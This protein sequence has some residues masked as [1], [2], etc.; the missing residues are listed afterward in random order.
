MDEHW[1]PMR[2]FKDNLDGPV[3][4]NIFS[5]SCHGKLFLGGV[6]IE[7]KVNDLENEEARY[8]CP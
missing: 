1:K 8:L 6:M 4:V 5:I 7:R 2:K 3:P